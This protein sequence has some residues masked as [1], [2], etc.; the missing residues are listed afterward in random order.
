VYVSPWFL[1]FTAFVGAN[2]LQ[3]AFTNWCPMMAFLRRLGFR[4]AAIVVLAAVAAAPARAQGTEPGGTA[5]TIAFVGGAT[6]TSSAG[7]LIGGTVVYD[8]NRY[9]ALEGQ[10]AWFDRG[11]RAEAYMANASVLANLVPRG[12]PAVPYLAGGVGVYRASFDVPFVAGGWSVDWMPRFYARRMAMMPF[13]PAVAFEART[14]TDP[15][16]TMGGGVRVTLATHL[17]LRPDARALVVLDGGDSHT[18]G[19]VGLNIGYRF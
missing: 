1:A 3:S 14:F 12:R 18:I 7:A 4:A 17:E 15:V 11:A 19:I 2:L 8:V 16:V 6:T 13:R 5:S 9:V 10:G